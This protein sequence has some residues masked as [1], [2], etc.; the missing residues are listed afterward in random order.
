MPLAM[1]P[2][3]PFRRREQKPGSDSAPL[4]SCVTLA[5]VRLAETNA[6]FS[7]YRERWPALHQIRNLKREEKDIILFDVGSG[8]G[9]ISLMP[10]PIPW[11]D[12]EIQCQLAFWWEGAEKVLRAHRAHVIV[13]LNDSSI[14]PVGRAQMLTRLVDSVAHGCRATGIV[15]GSGGVVSSLQWFCAAA[16][17]LDEQQYPVPIWVSFRPE[18][19]DD[20]S[21]SLS[22]LG[23][24]DL[25]CWE[26]EVHHARA[27]PANV[28]EYVGDFALYLLQRGSVVKDGD[29]FGYAAE[30][31]IRIHLR[32]KGKW[33][34]E[35]VYELEFPH[36]D[37]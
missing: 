21:V 2:L 13:G 32:K 31:K 17:E 30:D 15:W 24:R 16:C 12:L 1:S 7:H 26:V 22:T 5:E 25:G 3:L 23:L 19:H 4:V 33:F 18:T 10:T 36:S 6:L 14:S 34:R 28:L 35:P 20:Q 9:F 11:S 29:T 37:S 27:K 8:T